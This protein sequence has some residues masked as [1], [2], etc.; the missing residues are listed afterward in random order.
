[1][2][3]V[4]LVSSCEKAID[5]SPTSVI[6]SSSFWKTP[7]DAKGAVIGLHDRLRSTAFEELFILGEARS[8][9][10]GRSTQGSQGIDRYYN[11]TL[12][13]TTLQPPNWINFYSTINQANLI[14]KYVP[15][16]TFASE[17]EKNRI[18][19]QAYTMRAFVYYNLVRAWGGVPIRTEPTE[20][21]DA[22]SI[23]LSRSS[24]EDVFTLIKSD[25]DEAIKLYP[26][27][28][29]PI[30]RAFW[31]KS[32]ANT[33]KGDVYLWTGKRLNGGQSDFTTSLSALNDA[34]TADVSLL[35]DYNAIFD[36]DNKGNKEILFA[37]RFDVIETDHNYYKYMY[38]NDGGL[39]VTPET[40]A[41]IGTV[42]SG[43]NGN[44][45]MEVT[46]EVRSQFSVDDQRR[47]GTFFEVY[48]TTGTYL[49]S[50]TTKGRGVVDNGTRHFKSDIIIYRFA[51]LL[52]LI[53][54]AK[55]A[56]GQNPEA[57]INMVRQRAYGAKFSNYAF[58][59]NSQQVNDDIILKERLL[60]LATEG[61]RWW[62]LLRFDKAFELVPALQGRSSERHLLLFPIGN[63]IRS[64][65]P[66]VDENPG[67]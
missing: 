65:E 1:M 60:E 14:I 42:G 47:L 36:Y 67:W 11:Q 2:L 51:D 30:G 57:E 29:I 33:L 31:S 38:I 64:L 17:A 49:S 63:N 34:R 26:D 59:S 54:E 24:V 8:E 32:A 45:I 58:V 12:N 55:N 35:S 40:R 50:I 4:L 23:Q 22:E 20:S 44:A 18:L 19:A 5:V 15:T 27:N 48:N 25:L 61:K 16:I 37:I 7:D 53:A 21:Y 28:N 52:L 13:S 39:A 62:D 3:A 46:P 6:T 56:L 10:I 41:F 66:F 9:V 43:N